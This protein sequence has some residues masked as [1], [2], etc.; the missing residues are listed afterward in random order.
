MSYGQ[1]AILIEGV[2]A[3]ILSTER[4][5]KKYNTMVGACVKLRCFQIV[6]RLD[7]IIYIGLLSRVISTVVDQTGRF[8]ILCTLCSSSNCWCDEN[9]IIE[10]R[11]S[12]RIICKTALYLQ[13]IRERETRLHSIR[14]CHCG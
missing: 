5:C 3:V 7:V 8:S 2:I 1:T 14:W 6:H 12:Q 9:R 10:I 4:I 11:R 13:V